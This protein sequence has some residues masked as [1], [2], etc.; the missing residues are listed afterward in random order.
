ME[1]NKKGTWEKKKNPT[2]N[3]YTA[4]PYTKVEKKKEK[5]AEKGWVTNTAFMEYQILA[6]WLKDLPGLEQMVEKNGSPS[7]KKILAMALL[8]TCLMVLPGTKHLLNLFS[9]LHVIPLFYLYR[10][11]KHGLD[12]IWKN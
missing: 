5:K 4:A 2:S 9:S 12:S 1:M 3:K 7:L 10:S 11:T 6:K 8:D